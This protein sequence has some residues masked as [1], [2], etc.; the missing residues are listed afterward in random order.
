VTTIGPKRTAC[1]AWLIQASR[2]DERARAFWDAAAAASTEMERK[3]HEAQALGA[4]QDAIE[5]RQYAEAQE[6]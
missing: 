3:R 4:E 5:A 6:G 2:Y 1:E